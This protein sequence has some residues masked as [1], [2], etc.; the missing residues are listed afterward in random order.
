[1]DE[2]STTDVSV[3]GSPTRAELEGAMPDV[4]DILS[5][6]LASAGI[7]MRMALTEI[8]P[9]DMAREPGD[10][11]SGA[12]LRPADSPSAAETRLREGTGKAAR[13]ASF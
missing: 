2:T 6:S 10:A 3:S 5:G 12:K 9:E 13:M 11:S 8:S 4:R 7:A 1:M